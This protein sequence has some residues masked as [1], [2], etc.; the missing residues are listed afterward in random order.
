LIAVVENGKVVELG[1]PKDLLSK[2]N[3]VFGS[4]VDA[5]PGGDGAKMRTRVMRE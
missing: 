2:E 3:S 4:L 5:A 1:S